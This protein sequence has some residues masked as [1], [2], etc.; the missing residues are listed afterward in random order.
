MIAV[1]SNTGKC[2]I[3]ITVNNYMVPGVVFDETLQ[4]DEEAYVKYVSFWKQAQTLLGQT[5]SI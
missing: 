3:D 1:H 2:D 4:G 5:Q